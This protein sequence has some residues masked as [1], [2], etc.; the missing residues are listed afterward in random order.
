MSYGLLVG[1]MEICYFRFK[2]Y[3][4]IIFRYS[5]SGTSKV[6]VLFH[7]SC[8]WQPSNVCK[9]KEA[10]DMAQVRAR[11]GSAKPCSNGFGAEGLDSYRPP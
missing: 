6:T 5:L 7:V 10:A 8:H 4:G 2:D 11:L 9:L 1:N 3:A